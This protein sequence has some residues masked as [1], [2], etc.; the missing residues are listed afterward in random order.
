M[1]GLGLWKSISV[2]PTA[3]CWEPAPESPWGS[4]QARDGEGSPVLFSSA[5]LVPG[6]AAHPALHFAHTWRISLITPCSGTPAWRSSLQASKFWQCQQIPFSPPSSHLT[7]GI[8]LFQPC[9]TWLTDL[10][11]T[12][13]THITGTVPASDTPQLTDRPCGEWADFSVFISVLSLLA[14]FWWAPGRQ[15]VFLLLLV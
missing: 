1:L 9:S 3:P 10:T 14:L 2:L 4:L 5:W 13:L 7:V 8:L 6:E 11:I 12:S 15:A